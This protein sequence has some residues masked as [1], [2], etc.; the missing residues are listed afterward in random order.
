[1]G[2]GGG[3]WVLLRLEYGVG[4]L[5]C[6]IPKHIFAFSIGGRFFFNTFQRFG[7]N[8]RCIVREV[9]GL[10]TKA[11]EVFGPIARLTD[12]VFSREDAVVSVTPF[13]WTS[14]PWTLVEHA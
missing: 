6:P 11:W 14:G 7:K 8:A 5:D 4:F 2:S 12:R 10:K 1:M 3:R 9:S 13:A